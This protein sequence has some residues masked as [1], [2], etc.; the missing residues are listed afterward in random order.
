M[1]MNSLSDEGIIAALYDASRAGVKIR[2]NVRGIC[3]LKP[4]VPGMSENITVVS[5]VDYY[6]EHARIFHFRNGG[7]DDLY[8]SSAD[9]M[10]RN[11]DRRVELMI[12]VLAP[13]PRKKLLATLDVYFTDR[14]KARTLGPN[15][16]YRLVVAHGKEQ[17]VR[18][19]EELYKRAKAAARLLEQTKPTMLEPY[20]R[21]HNQQT[22]TKP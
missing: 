11:L 19:Q 17:P 9:M 14:V 1:K 20:Q 13:G 3:C 21:K 5:I 16:E 22:D 12:P 4:G 2:L 7:L 18:A 8:I 6:L 10:K 15:G